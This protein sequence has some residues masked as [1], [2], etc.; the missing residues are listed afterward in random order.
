[1]PQGQ[2]NRRRPVVPQPR[3]QRPQPSS[4][5]TEATPTLTPIDRP[6]PS[7]RLRWTAMAGLLLAVNT[8]GYWLAVQEARPTGETAAALRDLFIV[9][10]LLTIALGLMLPGRASRA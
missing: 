9:T 1:M 4:N 3:V 8:A 10:S 5:R 7:L 6:R 2:I